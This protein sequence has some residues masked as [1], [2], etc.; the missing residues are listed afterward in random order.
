MPDLNKFQVGD[1]VKL[2]KKWG[3]DFVDLTVTSPP[4]MI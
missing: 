4:T 1:S 2:L 3:E